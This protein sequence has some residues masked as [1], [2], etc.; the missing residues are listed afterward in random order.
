VNFVIEPEPAQSLA[1]EKR[2]AFYR[3]FPANWQIW[4]TRTRNKSLRGIAKSSKVYF[5]DGA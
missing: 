5:F 3:D 1:P 4:M 2:N